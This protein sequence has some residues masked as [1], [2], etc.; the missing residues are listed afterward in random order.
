MD[1]RLGHVAGPPRGDDRR[2][3]A[4]VT[5]GAG[6]IGS[7][8]VDALLERGDE[9]AVA[10]DLS[11]GRDANIGAAIEQGTPLVVGDQQVA[12]VLEEQRRQRAIQVYTDLNSPAA[13]AA[14]SS[15]A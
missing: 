10:D 6:F 8:L 2:L 12:P 1:F 5:G 4:L 13:P 11:S 15:R 9:V 3:R 14:L 7:H